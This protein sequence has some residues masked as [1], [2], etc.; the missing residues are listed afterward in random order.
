MK[1][2]LRR[3]TRIVSLISMSILLVVFV[4][5]SKGT[6]G[7]KSAAELT[8]EGWELFES[9]NFPSGKAKFSQALGKDGEYAD[10][11]NGRGWCNAFLDLD[12]EAISDFDAANSKGLGQPDTYA[13]LAGVYVG[14]QE[15]LSAISNAKTV[16]SQDS[17]Y[18]FSHQ[19]AIDSLDLH[20][21]L[22][23]AYY[24]LGGA[25]IDSAQQRVDYLNPANDLDPINPATWVVS[26]FAYGTYAE[27]LLKEIQLL[28]EI[29]GGY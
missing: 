10:A 17:S 13:G 29:I 12:T 14:N 26:G 16:L 8:A 15:F 3:V 22:A 4:S 27:A 25:Y 11:Y 20:L 23:Q 21:I 19:P 24:G 5:C 18:Q 28:E 1:K 2:D 7:D 9:S 6:N